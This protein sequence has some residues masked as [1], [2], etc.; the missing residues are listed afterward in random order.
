MMPALCIVSMAG[1]YTLVSRKSLISPMWFLS[2]PVAAALLIYSMLRSMLITLR[3]GG[4]A[5]GA[6]PYPLRTLKR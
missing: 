1:L 2:A 4:V 5:C 3:H 6:A